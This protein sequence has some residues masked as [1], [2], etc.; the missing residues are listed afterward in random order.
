[1]LGYIVKRLL[2]AVPVLIGVS[3]VNHT[4]LCH[5]PGDPTAQ[6]P[7]SI[8]AED[9]ARII[10]DLGRNQPCHIRYLNWARHMFINEP[11]CLAEQWALQPMSSRKS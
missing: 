5:A 3:F 6:L 11:A 7:L 9:R 4:I 2:F 8:P 10:D 1:M